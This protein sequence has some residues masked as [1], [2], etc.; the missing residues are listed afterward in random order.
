MIWVNFFHFCFFFFFFLL[1]NLFWIFCFRNTLC[2]KTLKWKSSL[3][4]ATF[5]IIMY[6]FYDKIK[7]LL[8]FVYCSFKTCTHFC[9]FSQIRK[10]CGYCMFFKKNNYSSP[11]FACFTVFRFLSFVYIY[12]DT[13]IITPRLFVCLCS[14][15]SSRPTPL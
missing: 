13:F 2:N 6:F 14:W 10:V 15:Q 5:M 9:V 4:L 3:T 12:N 11:F 7:K 1:F 8:S